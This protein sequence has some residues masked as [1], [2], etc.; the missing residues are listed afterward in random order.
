MPGGVGFFLKSDE[1][2]DE[3]DLQGIFVP[4]AGAMGIRH[5]FSGPAEPDSVGLQLYQVNPRSRGALTLRSADP[6]AHP[7]LI[8]N[9]Y[10]D[11]Q[12]RAAI[13]GGV[14]VARRIF[15][16]P[17]FA[18][19]Q[20]GEMDPGTG[21][22]SDAEIDAWVARTACTIYHPVGT[23]RM[24]SDSDATAVVDGQLQVR[25]IDG[26]RVADASIMP[27]IT[28]GNTHAPTLFIAQRCAD[29]MRDA[30]RPCSILT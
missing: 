1:A 4:G 27:R 28:S 2:L 9:Y 24:G 12:D 8:A 3:P 29:F 30:N 7:R 20:T 13:R 19:Y 6:F 16:Q 14:R 11:P 5:P 18:P 26:L 23:C 22:Q 21:V 25:G 10:A 17:A 15:D